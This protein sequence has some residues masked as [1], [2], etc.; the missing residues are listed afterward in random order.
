[1]FDISDVFLFED[2][3]IRKRLSELIESDNILPI[4]E[5]ENMTKNFTNK[6]IL[7]LFFWRIKL[8]GIKFI[9]DKSQNKNICELKKEHFV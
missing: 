8:E 2:L 5:C 1:M 7:S 6:R 9:L 4:K 3:W